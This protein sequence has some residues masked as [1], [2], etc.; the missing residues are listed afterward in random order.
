MGNDN[1]IS[2][3]ELR[4][5]QALERDNKTLYKIDDTFFN[6]VKEYLAI[7]KKLIEQNKNSDNIFAKESVFTAEIELKNANKIIVDLASRR[8]RKIVMQA[9]TNIY[10]RAH[11]TERMLNFEE[12]FYYKI[13]EELRTYIETFLSNFDESKQSLE[14]KKSEGEFLLIRF[15]EDVPKFAWKDGNDYGPFGKEDV[16]NLPKEISEFL[17]SQSK[18][19]LMEVEDN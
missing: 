5:I 1:L 7:K 13:L 2:Y 11:D 14:I 16:A 10:S 9:L 17:I 8:V 18:A 4:K 19:V 15:L 12:R 3:E 6:R